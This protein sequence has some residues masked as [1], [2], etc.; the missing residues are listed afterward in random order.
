LFFK[1]IEASIISIVKKAQKQGLKPCIRLNG[2]SD[3]PFEN[4]RVYDGLSVFERFPEVQ[5]YDYTKNPYRILNKDMPKNY[6]LTFSGSMERLDLFDKVKNS[7]KKVN[8]ALVFKSVPKTYDGI[9]CINGD[10]H[11]LRFLNKGKMSI[12]ALTA[13]GAAKK[14]TSGFVIQ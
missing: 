8:I 11:D 6:H 13:K 10:S 7:G 9:K 2:T 14:D 12:I 3:I 5:F 4:Y 1:N